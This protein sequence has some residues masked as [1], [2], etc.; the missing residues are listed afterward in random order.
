MRNRE[1]DC[2]YINL[3]SATQRR[4][5]LESNFAAVKKPH[6][7]LTRFAAVD[8]AFVTDND[9]KGASKPA[10]KA[11]FLSHKILIGQ[12]LDGDAPMLIVEDDAAFGYRTCTLIEA[13]LKHNKDKDWDILF[14]DL[15]ITSLKNMI[16]LL[17]YRRELKQKKIEIAFME[18]EQMAFA[19]STAYIV[20][21]KSKRKL[22]DLLGAATELD[23]PYD[24]HL[25][26]MIHRSTL[27]GFS[28]FP[29]V[30]SL[31][32]FS[33]ESQIRASDT[34]RP[35]IAWNMFRK[36]VWV[37]RNLER[38]KTGLESMKKILSDQDMSAFRLLFASRDE[39]LNAFAILFSLVGANGTL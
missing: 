37:E 9:I 7:T 27:K 25:R 13:I 30:T 4:S 38:C 29:F 1:M 8:T 32:E 10:E 24:L 12:N 6:W 5:N 19:G 20:N 35:D 26:R 31:S 16:E 28:L 3:D 33:E 36:M 14:T 39:E 11:C 17:K 23:L 22:Y 21:A 15:C 18:I 2:F 34:D